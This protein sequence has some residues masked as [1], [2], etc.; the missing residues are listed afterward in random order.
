M[1][2]PQ[3]LLANLPISRYDEKHPD[4]KFAK[5]AKAFADDVKEK[6]NEAFNGAAEEKAKNS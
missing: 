6:I 4:V 2:I 3:K 1:S 5:D